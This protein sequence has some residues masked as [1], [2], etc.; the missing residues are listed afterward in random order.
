MVLKRTMYLGCLKVKD[1]RVC[2]IVT[3]PLCLNLRG[4]QLALLMRHHGSTL[5][6]NKALHFGD[7]RE[8]SRP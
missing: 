2:R 5:V 1:L 6:S 7:H 3:I 8:L 4:K